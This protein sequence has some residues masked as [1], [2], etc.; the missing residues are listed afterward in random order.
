MKLTEE[1]IEK[2]K[3]KESNMTE[4][5]AF[6]YYRTYSRYLDDKQRREYW[7]ETVKRSV[8]YNCSLKPTNKEEAEKLY[9]NIFNLKQ[10]LSGRTL[11]TANTASSLKF[12][13]SNFN[14]ASVVI[15]EIESFHDMFYLLMLGCGVGFRVLQDDVDKLPNFRNNIKITHSPYQEE[16]YKYEDT[17]ISHNGNITTI[18]IGDSKGGWTT[19]YKALLNMHTCQTVEEIIINYS[20][21]RPKGRRL[22]TFG[23][24]A[25]G[26]E[27]LQ[28]L[29]EKTCSVI[30]S[31]NGRLKTI[32]C[33]DMCNLICESV[34][35]GGVRRSASI[36]MFDI[37]D[38][39]VLN[40]KNSIYYIDGEGNWQTNKELMHRTKS[41]CIL[42]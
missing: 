29:F 24:S 39:E 1:F 28:E 30:K 9:D 11:Y 3:N 7:Y 22:K 27:A 35:V 33:L 16:Q 36:C 6:V 26:H 2:Y 18:T 15:D 17:E 40:A 41:N 34:V 31:A 32:D 37:N 10:F 25:S 20:N 12:P 4:L 8:E 14:C 23:G 21:V 38:T 13:S 42:V 5:G 19:G